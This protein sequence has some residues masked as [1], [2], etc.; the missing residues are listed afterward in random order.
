MSTKNTVVPVELPSQDGMAE[1]AIEPAELAYFQRVAQGLIRA[2]ELESQ[3][4][5]LL[6]Q[7]T[8]LRGAYDSWIG[9]LIERYGLDPEHDEIDPER[10]LILHRDG[11]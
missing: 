1:R 3:A 5:S 8:G 6:G 2:G 11:R 7:A 4:A 9:H 10:G